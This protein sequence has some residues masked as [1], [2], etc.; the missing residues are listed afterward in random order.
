MLS[1]SQ[2]AP[3]GSAYIPAF[4]C[5]LYFQTGSCQTVLVGKDSAQR[6]VSAI[7][8]EHVLANQR[9]LVLPSCCVI[10]HSAH[11]QHTFCRTCI[12]QTAVM[13]CRMSSLGNG[14][15]YNQSKYRSIRE[16]QL[17]EG[18]VLGIQLDGSTTDFQLACSWVHNLHYHLWA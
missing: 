15:P 9:N 7:E 18:S 17:P 1:R 10:H 3:S 12:H 8:S 6:Q 13:D 5:S 14:I 4:G 16:K 2:I 11:L